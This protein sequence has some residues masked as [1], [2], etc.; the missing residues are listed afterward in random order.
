MEIK[1][2]IPP[3]PCPDVSFF[4]SACSPW[5][6][7]STNGEKDSAFSVT[8]SEKTLAHVC[9]PPLQNFLSS[10]FFLHSVFHGSSVS[11]SDLP[12]VTDVPLLAFAVTFIKPFH[13]LTK[14]PLVWVYQ[15]FH[16]RTL[17]KCAER[18]ILTVLF[19]AKPLIN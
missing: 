11:H 4:I 15:L 14:D 9:P 3:Q 7:L 10:L 1:K 2:E 18:G 16:T 12:H 5:E 13:F 8:L 6:I 17:N 19:Q